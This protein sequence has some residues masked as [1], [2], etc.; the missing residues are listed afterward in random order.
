[1]LLTGFSVCAN[2]ATLVLLIQKGGQAHLLLRIRM[3]PTWPLQ[4]VHIPTRSKS[5]SSG[6]HRL[7]SCTTSLTSSTL[8]RSIKPTLTYTIP[9]PVTRFFHK[10]LLL[11]FHVG[12]NQLLL[13][14]FR[15]FLRFKR[16]PHGP[17]F[18]VGTLFGGRHHFRLYSR[19]SRRSNSPARYSIG[20]AWRSGEFCR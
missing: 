10:L 8:R 16:H 5:Y 4:E 7:H 11:F 2:S 15:Y 12:Y 6:I 20:R 17:L 1:M 14:H 9:A 3:W 13:Q 19:N 18:H